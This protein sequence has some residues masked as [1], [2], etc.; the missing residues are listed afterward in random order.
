MLTRRASLALIASAG[1]A[2]L[3]MPKGAFAR[4]KVFQTK[5]IA[6]G[7]YDP[8]AYFS[9][10]GPV[11]GSGDFQSSFAGANWLFANAANKALFDGDPEKYMP[12][13]GGYCAYA[14]SKGAIAPTVP[15]AWTVH[16]DRLYLN[17][18]TDV[19]EIWRADIDT[20]IALANENWPSLVA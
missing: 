8:V 14:V 9:A 17:F 19:R 6:I 10:G 4:D 11:R 1:A 3:L 16:K 20:N 2:A 12:K 5:G 15:E 7:G 18:S 13:Y